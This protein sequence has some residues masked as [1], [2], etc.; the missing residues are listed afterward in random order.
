MLPPLL[1]A[2]TKRHYYLTELCLFVR[3]IQ[4][5]LSKAL[6]SDLSFTIIGE[7][8]VTQLFSEVIMANDT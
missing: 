7:R 2:R 1:I 3:R 4:V 8:K 5:F 6:T